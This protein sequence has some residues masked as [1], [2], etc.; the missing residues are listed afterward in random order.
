MLLGQLFRRCSGGTKS[1]RGHEEESCPSAGGLSEVVPEADGPD[2]RGDA[3]QR[4]LRNAGAG[5]LPGMLSQRCQ[6]HSLREAAN[7]CAAAGLYAKEERQKEFA[8]CVR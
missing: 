6:V 2:Q 1:R 4:S 5:A 8:G 7:L 3:G